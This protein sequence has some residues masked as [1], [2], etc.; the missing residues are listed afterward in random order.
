MKPHITS[1]VA[2]PVQILKSSKGVSLLEVLVALVL[3]S[4]ALLSFS[5]LST[6]AFK[7]IVG[8]KKLTL[9]TILAQDKL[10]SVTLAGYDST[11]R[12]PEE[13]QESYGTIKDYPGFQRTV[14]RLPHRPGQRMQTVRVT[15]SWDQ[16]AH[17]S[18]LS[19]ILGE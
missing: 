5:T 3:I 6:V 16:R 13:V 19:V 10:E 18:T 12:S 1:Q 14:T 11:L 9:G 7:G 2:S 15:V 4:L 17:S 8:S